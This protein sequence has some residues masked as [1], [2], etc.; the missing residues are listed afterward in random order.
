VLSDH[1]GSASTITDAL[2]GVYAT[3]KYWPYGGTRSVTGGVPTDKQYTGQQIE[4]G[5]ALGLY[6]Y[7]ARFYSTVVG[8]FVSADPVALRARYEYVFNN[9]L[10]NVDPTGLTAMIACG[11]RQHCENGADIGHYR[12]AIEE[13]WRQEN[14]YPGADQ[15]FLDFVFDRYFLNAFR[16]IAGFNGQ[17][18]ADI[19]GVVFVDTGG[20]RENGWNHFA[21]EPDIGDFLR[22]NREFFGVGGAD[23]WIG[24]SFGGELVWEALLNVWSSAA[25]YTPFSGGLPR[26][27]LLL[28]PSIGHRTAPDG[29][30]EAVRVVV[31]NGPHAGHNRLLPDLPGVQ[32]ATVTGAVH[33]WSS[34]CIGEDSNH[35]A[36]PQSQALGVAFA[37]TPPGQAEDQAIA[38]EAASAGAELVP[39]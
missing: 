32:N 11:T 27:V 31:I 12:N 10:R 39:W 3:Q 23:L 15:S 22:R 33:I 30:L 28:Q 13:E 25:G 1:L 36:H 37:M 6:N 5:D 14:R 35:C 17:Q 34:E 2:G 7:K 18:S 8:R 38:L 4:P 24:Y 16:L 20:L 26:G 19:F 9:P 21:G 29:L